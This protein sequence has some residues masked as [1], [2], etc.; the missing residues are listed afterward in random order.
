MRLAGAILLAALLP[1]SLAGCGDSLP[2]PGNIPPLPPEPLPT[3]PLADKPAPVDLLPEEGAARA[4]AGFLRALAEGK[5]KAAATYLD[6]KGGDQVR[7]LRE[8]LLQGGGK[9]LDRVREFFPR[10][11]SFTPKPRILDENRVAFLLPMGPGGKRLLE[12]R[13]HHQKNR[14][15]LLHLLLARSKN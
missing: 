6:R 8:E 3:G 2:P 11:G 14:L 7:A 1:G 12:A 4:L 13:F 5:A 10:P 9:Q 15:W